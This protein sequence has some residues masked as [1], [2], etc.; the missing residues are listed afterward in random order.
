MAIGNLG[1][2]EEISNMSGRPSP[3]ELF[4]QAVCAAKLHYGNLHVYP[5]TYLAGYYYRK[6]QYKKAICTWTEAANV[7]RK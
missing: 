5:Y 7:I 1:E 3:L 6:G 2:L 4:H